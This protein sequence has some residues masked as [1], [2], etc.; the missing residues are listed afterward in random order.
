MTIPSAYVAKGIGDKLTSGDAN[1]LNADIQMALDKRAG[2]TDALASI[3]SAGGAG[4]IVDSYAAAADVPSTTYLLSGG[5]SII[6]ASAITAQRQGTLSNTGA[7]AGDRLMI[8]NQSN[9]PFL[10]LNAAATLIAVIG[11]DVL[12]GNDSTWVDFLFNGT[13]W[14][15]WRSAKPTTLA[16]TVFTASGTFI[17]PRGV[18]TLLVIGFG[19]GGAGGGGSGGS[20]V[21]AS[22]STGGGGGG[23]SQQG[24]ALVTS[25]GGTSITVTIGA[26]GLS[27]INNNAG[28]DGSPSLFGAL[29]TFPAAGGGASTTGAGASFALETFGGTPV[30]LSAAMTSQFYNNRTQLIPNPVG[31]SVQI[32]P[33]SGGRS[34]NQAGANVGYFSLSGTP[35]VQGFAGGA[36]A[37]PGATSTG[38]GGG[39]GAGG[40]G[41]PAGAGGVGG[42]GG[43]G[44]SAVAGGFGLNGTGAAN[45]SGA[46]G[47]GGG[48]GGTSA[49]G[50]GI[51]GSSGAGG[52]GQI[53]VIPLR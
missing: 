52:S 19:G 5:N 45:N 38:V 36:G 39:G 46:G 41:G 22:G 33:G 28:N 16:S 31:D 42:V 26:G 6:N 4:R 44:S 25:S 23:G 1:T 21:N 27:V 8:L 50:P 20:T 7:I 2:Q 3:V 24:L 10:V 35:S 11:P 30:A 15:V 12:G 43:P 48:G 18:S 17:V 29:A 40:G 53:I 51:G 34:L 9:F 37:G 49:I 47:G 32:S 14:I 13:A